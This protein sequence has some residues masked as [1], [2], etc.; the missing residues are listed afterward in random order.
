MYTDN[1]NNQNSQP[2]TYDRICLVPKYSTLPSRSEAST[3]TSF[4]GKK[5]LMP[6]IPANMESVIDDRI[7]RQFSESGYF[8]IMHRFKN[9][10]TKFVEENQ[11]LQLISISVGVNAESMAEI[12]YLSTRKFKVDVITIDVAHAHHDKVREMMA[13]ISKSY[14]HRNGAQVIAGNVATREGYKFLCGLGVDAVKVG[15]GGGSI[16]TTRY[17]TGFHVPTAQSV[18]ECTGYG[19]D[20][21]IIADGGAKHHGDI[22]KA[23]VLGADMV[24]SGAFFASCIDSPA[25]IRD[26]KKV[27]YGSTSYMAK[28]EHRHIEGRELMLDHSCTIEE[29]V[30]EIREDLCSSISYAGGHDLSAFRT[31]KWFML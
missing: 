23:L 13:Y 16:C 25:P 26:G 14:L 29:R 17:K 4:L 31:T 22:A 6:V 19:H 11:D 8:Y 9:A 27:Y 24:M 18:W 3:M 1:I 20:V 12:E 7:A 10:T 30:K 2:L 15:I 21:P 5:Y 28:G